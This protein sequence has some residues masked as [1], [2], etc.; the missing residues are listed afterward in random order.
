MSGDTV[1]LS[2][3]QPRAIRSALAV[4]RHVAAA[5][6]GVTAKEIS[7]A[8]GLAPAT[9]YRLLNLLV[10]EEYL[11]RMPDL[12]GF[13]LGR[14]VA[15]LTGPRPVPAVPAAAHAAVSRL[16]DQLRFG[17]HLAGYA[18]GRID[19]T[20]PDPDHPPTDAAF[21]TRHPHASALGKLLLADAHT[22]PSH[23]AALTGHTITTHEALAAELVRVRT[24]GVA[25]QQCELDPLHACLAVPV[26]SETTGRLAAG[27]AVCGTPDRIGAVARPG[28][29]SALVDQLRECARRLAPLVV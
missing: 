1:A 21:L 16:R 23:L 4:L 3:R 11:V 8:L 10:E 12:R 26:H 18:D 6:P 25:M 9:T 24:D 2:G 20:D 19:F 5:A 29:P 15:E 28:E 27:L 14:R 7:A 13:A 22:M 17:V